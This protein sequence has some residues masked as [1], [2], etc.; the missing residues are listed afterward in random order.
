MAQAEVRYVLLESAAGYGLF[1]RK[2]GDEVSSKSASV[3]YDRL[4]QCARAQ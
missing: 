2:G 3:E 1:E 4:A